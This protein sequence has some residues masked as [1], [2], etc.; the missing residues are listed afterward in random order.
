MT[1]C[2]KGRKYKGQTVQTLK[3]SVRCFARMEKN[4]VEITCSSKKIVC[5]FLSQ[6][7]LFCKQFWEKKSKFW[8][9]NSEF[10]FYILQFWLFSQ[11]AI[12]FLLQ[13]KK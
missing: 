5:D 12:V 2:K 10:T 13:N 1:H 6:F 7:I 9:I 4:N 11:L 8:D 3:M